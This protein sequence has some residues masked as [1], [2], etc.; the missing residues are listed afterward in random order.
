MRRHDT[1]GVDDLFAVHAESTGIA[2]FTVN[3]PLQPTGTGDTPSRR[4]IFSCTP[5]SADEE[6]ACAAEILEGIATRAYRRP[7]AAED[8]ALATLLGFY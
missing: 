8:P 6:A 7:V 2:S 5:A 3:G 4:R 1:E